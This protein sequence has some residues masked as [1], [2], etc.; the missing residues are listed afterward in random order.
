MLDLAI[1][2]DCKAN[3]S[4]WLTKFVTTVKIAINNEMGKISSIEIKVF[5]LISLNMSFAAIFPATAS[6][7]EFPNRVVRKIPTNP[8]ISK[9]DT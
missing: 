2:Q 8:I 9:D 6:D 7:S 5:R 4:L 3:H 1:P